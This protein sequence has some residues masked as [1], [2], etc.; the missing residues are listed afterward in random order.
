MLERQ[1]YELV[2]LELVPRSQVL[3]L[4]VDHPDGVTLDDCTGVSRVVSDMLDAE[5]YSDRFRGRF[6]LEVSSPGLDRPLVKPAHFQRFVGQKARLVTKLPQAGR[7]NFQGVLVAADA[8]EVR[9]EIDGQAFVLR[10][11]QI[12]NARLVP[13]F[14]SGAVRP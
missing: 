5:G 11:E 10:Y 13:E 9:L 14:S 8:A 3:R 4:F 7:R 1:G 2:L 6:T 12:A